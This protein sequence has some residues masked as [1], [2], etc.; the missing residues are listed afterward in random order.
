MGMTPWTVSSSTC[1]KTSIVHID[2][3]LQQ[4]SPFPIQYFKN[5]LKE[6]FVIFL[7][8]HPLHYLTSLPQSLWIS[9]EVMDWFI[10]SCLLKLLRGHF[11]NLFPLTHCRCIELL[12]LRN[13]DDSRSVSSETPF[14]NPILSFRVLK[15]ILSYLILYFTKYQCSEDYFAKI[16]VDKIIELLHEVLVSVA[17]HS[18]YFIDSGKLAW[19]VAP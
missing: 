4:S 18:Y 16:V 7:H 14:D 1:R 5:V 10:E 2:G 6:F 8:L 3:C 13:D 17:S 9:T 11:S 19:M 12:D 15:N